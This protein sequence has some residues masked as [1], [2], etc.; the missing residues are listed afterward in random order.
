MPRPKETAGWSNNS[1]PSQQSGPLGSL[2]EINAALGA[3]V[4]GGPK[5]DFLGEAGQAVFIGF[6]RCCSASASFFPHPLG[7]LLDEQGEA[8]SI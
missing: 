5:Q 4:N 8:H 1:D 2:K 7:K 6:Y 3:Q